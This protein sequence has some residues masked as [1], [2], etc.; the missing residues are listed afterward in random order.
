MPCQ[1]GMATVT[2][3]MQVFIKYCGRADIEAEKLRSD[4]NIRG[5]VEEP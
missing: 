4:I 3:G 1:Y 2:I 5:R